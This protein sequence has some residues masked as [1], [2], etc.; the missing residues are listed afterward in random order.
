M[1]LDELG[2]SLFSCHIPLGA[3]HPG[4]W[5]GGGMVVRSS[6]QIPAS[7]LPGGRRGM[8]RPVPSPPVAP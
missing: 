2:I 3:Q 7:A 8:R 6:T 5:G 1:R 4:A